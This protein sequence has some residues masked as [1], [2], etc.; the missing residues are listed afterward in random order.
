[1]KRQI[2]LFSSHLTLAFILQSLSKPSSSGG[3][4]APK[5]TC[6]SYP[7]SHTFSNVQAWGDVLFNTP[8]IYS[9]S[10][11]LQRG[12]IIS[13][14]IKAS[15]ACDYTWSKTYQEA[16]KAVSGNTVTEV[17]LPQT[18]DYTTTIK[19][20]SPCYRDS[21]L[22]RTVKLVWTKT[23]NSMEIN[24]KTELGYPTKVDCASTKTIEGRTIMVREYQSSGRI[25]SSEMRRL[26]VLEEALI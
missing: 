1:M 14:T 21:Y 9:L 3:V 6:G 8:S 16:D 26:A 5:T 22:G 4:S 25:A 10:E 23:I 11:F 19:V 17:M 7:A 2:I 13:I 15:K 12:C 24:P 18:I 20:E